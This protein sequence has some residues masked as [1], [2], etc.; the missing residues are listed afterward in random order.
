[1]TLAS[2]VVFAALVLAAPHMPFPRL[3]FICFFLYTVM[4]PGYLAARLIAPRTTG[5]LRVLASFVFGTALCYG[6]LFIAAAFRLDIRL[7]GVCS[8][9]LAISLV[10][11]ERRCGTTAEEQPAPDDASMPPEATAHRLILC[12]LL[13]AV[14]L[15]ILIGGDPLL[16]SSD[17]ADHIAYIRTVARTHEA[18]PR[19]FYYRDGGIETRDIRKGMGQA[20][21]GALIAL[22]GHH[23]AGAVWSLLS[24]ISSLFLLVAFYGAGVMLFR[25]PSMGLL[26]AILVVLFYSGGLRDYGLAASAGGYAFGRAFYVTA[27]ALLPR[28]LARRKCGYGALMLTSAFAAACSHFTYFALIVFVTGV[29]TLSNVIAGRTAERVDALKRGFLV[30]A[31]VVLVNMPYLALRYFRDY[32]PANPIHT[33]VQGVLYLT[34]RFYMLNPVVFFQGAGP[35]G[36]LAFL[37]IFILWKKS[38]RDDPLRLFLHGLIAVYVLVFNPL[39]FPFLLG[40]MSYLLMRFE[41]AIPSLIVSAYLLRELWTALRHRN[42]EVSRL[43][44]VVGIAAVVVLLGYPLAK[45]PADFAY[46]GPAMRRVAAQS[47]RRLDDLFAFIERECPAGSVIAADPITSFGIPA[48]TDA[49]VICPYDQHS[50]PNDTSAVRRLRDCR[51]IFNAISSL[52]EMRDIMKNYGAQYLVINGRIPPNVPRLYWGIDDEAARALE[53]RLGEPMSPFRIIFDR[54]DCAVA[55]LGVCPTCAAIKQPRVRPPFLGD[56]LSRSTAER[57]PPSGID[58]VRIDSVQPS[59]TDAARGDSIDIDITW[60]ATAKCPF[61]SYVAYLRF[62]TPFPK[63]ALYRASYGKLYRKA[64]EEAAGHRFRFRFDFQ[65]LGGMNP[66]G[67]WPPFHEIKERVRLAIPTDIAPGEYAISLKMA[68]KTQYPNYVLKDIISDEDVYSGVKVGSIRI[69]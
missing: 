12:G 34:Q 43:G 61:S 41:F 14:S 13:V 30:G 2:T 55:R 35:L 46:G 37:S 3:L 39:W 56:T 17:S 40:K 65:P 20:M 23:D 57:L 19:E 6:V 7:I 21:W 18:F 67:T 52:P 50:T 33:G 1:M 8:P 9:L 16:Y 59:L 31:A 15:M 62:D 48:F 10:I 11:W 66:P 22:G 54:A 47:Y 27:L 58:G 29:F 69:D 36:G 5:T 60:V 51:R 25:S 63:N 53:V 32:A 38:K 28:C 44:A 45:T 64:I 24:L 68:R 26:A 49:Y 4:L 42:P